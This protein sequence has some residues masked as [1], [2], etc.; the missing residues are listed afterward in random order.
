[1]AETTHILG[2]PVFREGLE[3]VGT[4]VEGLPP[5]AFTAIL[6]SQRDLLVPLIRELGIRTE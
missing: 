3:R 6:R 2:Q 1:M 4:E 5:E